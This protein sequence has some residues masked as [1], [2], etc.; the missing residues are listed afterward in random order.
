MTA[1]RFIDTAIATVRESGQDVTVERVLAAAFTAW[2]AWRDS[3]IEA[4]A[5]RALA[6][7]PEHRLELLAPRV[8]GELIALGH[9]HELPASEDEWIE[10]AAWGLAI[11]RWLHRAA[12]GLEPAFDAGS[13]ELRELAEQ[14]VARQRALD[15]W[16]PL[17]A[18][19]YAEV[20]A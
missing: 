15:E 3:V 19:L 16:G 14:A 8:T 5:L 20:G 10:A 12:C 2:V 6:R 1:E 18:P 7:V 9:W 4:W 11:L 13:P 17:F